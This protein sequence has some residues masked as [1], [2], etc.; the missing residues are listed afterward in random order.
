MEKLFLANPI[1]CFI[2]GNQIS[3][4]HFFLNGCGP[5][6]NRLRH[7][8]WC[9]STTE[10]SRNLCRNLFQYANFQRFFQ[11]L[12]KQYESNEND[13]SYRSLQLCFRYNSTQLKISLQFLIKGVLIRGNNPQSSFLM[14][15]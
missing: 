4:F 6:R 9:L 3:S 11:I 15:W 8:I 14:Y 5:V 2:S 1:F 12:K 7:N 13:T 10:A